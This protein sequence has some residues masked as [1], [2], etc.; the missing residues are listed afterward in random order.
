MLPHIQADVL[1]R[2]NDSS[3]LL[4]CLHVHP[5]PSCSSIAEYLCFVFDIG[6]HLPPSG[7]STIKACGDRVLPA[8]K[9]LSSVYWIQWLFLYAICVVPLFWPR[10]MR[11]CRFVVTT[12]VQL[13]PVSCE[14]SFYV[15]IHVNITQTLI[16]KSKRKSRVFWHMT[17]LYIS[18]NYATTLV[19]KGLYEN[20]KYVCHVPGTTSSEETWESLQALIW[21]SPTFWG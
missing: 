16:S 9:G 17:L 15:I 3:G 21:F 10:W 11:L 2:W 18:A 8:L 1:Q 6:S 12:R 4:M 7:L 13:R 20:T 5:N 19:W 14:F